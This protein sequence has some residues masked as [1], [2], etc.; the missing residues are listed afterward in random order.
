M[1]KT[2]SGEEH[3]KMITEPKPRRFSQYQKPGA[4]IVAGI[5]LLGVGF[6]LGIEYQRDHQHTTAI[7]NTSQTNGSSP[8]RGQGNQNRTGG[9][10]RFGGQRPIL[11]QVTAV[12]GS[13]ITIND[14]T[15]TSQTYSITITTVVSDQGQTATAGSIKI[16]DKVAIVADTTDNKKAARILLNPTLGSG[17]RSSTN[18]PNSATIN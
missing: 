9:G 10:R 16:G 18:G 1:A 5:V 7:S 12:D 2:I 6:A 14:Q 11:G 15:G 3:K 8:Q 4:L 17:G 13:T